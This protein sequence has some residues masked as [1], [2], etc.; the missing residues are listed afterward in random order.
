[1]NAKM[2]MQDAIDQG[3]KVKT[4]VANDDVLSSSEGEKRKHRGVA[5]EVL[6]WN[7]GG[8]VKA[9]IGLVASHINLTNH[10]EYS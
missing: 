8:G 2:A 6:M 9:A 4:V 3:I 10:R 7:V 1:M 5:G